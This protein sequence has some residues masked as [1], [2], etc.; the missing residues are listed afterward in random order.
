[1]RLP[2]PERTSEATVPRARA[3]S[4]GGMET[5]PL[6]PMST[7]SSPARAPAP[8]G[9][10]GGVGRRDGDLAVGADEHDFVTRLGAGDVGDV[11][12]GQVHPDGA[13]GGSVLPADGDPAAGAPPAPPAA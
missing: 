10:A 6:G 1:M 5:L 11:G 4:V 8:R 3:G 13:H 12:Q 7:T 2:R 9:G